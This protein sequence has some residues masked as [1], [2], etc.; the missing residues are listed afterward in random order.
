MA[1]NVLVAEPGNGAWSSIAAGVRRQRPEAALLRVKDGEQA[2]RF[3]F[4]R[5]LFTETPQTPDLLVLAANLPKIPVEAIVS[6]LRQY[7][8]TSTTPVIIVRRERRRSDLVQA[9]QRQQWL[10]HQQ[11][12]A[13][14]GAEDLERDVAWAMQQLYGGPSTFTP[15]PE[16]GHGKLL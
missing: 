13:A 12:V 9:R 5:G 3:L 16:A 4:Y 8:P 6:R 7:P 14:V 10:E 11:A 1:F 2:M 15:A